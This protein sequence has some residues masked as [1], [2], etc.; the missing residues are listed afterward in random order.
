MVTC[1]CGKT[2][3]KVPSWLEGVSVTFVCH[4]CPNRTIKGITEVS[5]AQAALRENET[6]ALDEGFPAE[7][8]E[9]EDE[10]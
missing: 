2:I 5:L 10:A 7:A 8:D 4:N 6:G 9:D 1:S 3:E